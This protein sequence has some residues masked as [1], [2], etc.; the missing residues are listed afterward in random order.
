MSTRHSIF[1]SRPSE[2]LIEAEMTIKTAIDGWEHHHPMVDVIDKVEHGLL[3]RHRW[4]V[5]IGAILIQMSLGAIYAWGVFTGELTD[6]SGNFGFTTT[7]TQ[8]VFSVGLASFAA[9]MLIA[10][11]LV[12]D[13]GPRP[14]AIAGGLLLAT[15]YVLAGFFGGQFWVQV[16]CI[17]VLGGSGI[18]LAYVVPIAVG[19]RWFPDKKGLMTGFAVAGFGFGALLW[20]QLAGD[21]GHLIENFGVLNTFLIYGIVFGTLV[22]LGGLLMTYPPDGWKPSG[23][24]PPEAEI[25]QEASHEFTPHSMLNRPQFYALW[26]SFAF[27]A[28]GGLM[29]IGINKLYGRDALIDSGAFTDLA[30][31]G[32]AA[33]TAYAIAFALSNGLGRIGWGF[34][35]DRIG[36]RRSM[37]IMAVTQS[38]LMIAFYYMGGSLVA[39]YVFLALTGFNFGGNFALF[40]LATANW[41]GVKNLGINY[42]LMFSAYGL[43]GI[44]GPIM[45]GMFKDAGANDGLS[46][47]LAPFL[48]AGGLCMVAA[49]LV[50]ISKEPS[51]K[52]VLEPVTA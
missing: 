12:A 10:G 32:A 13:I 45:A 11:R 16:L 19:V 2:L 5:A 49:I 52:P 28:L 31:A 40:P 21:W 24:I 44:A 46:V 27:L 34:I 25:Q 47:W 50:K 29:L 35:A 43:G 22:H 30:A 33:S 17:G 8:W 36:W 20:V 37:M 1:H 23:W 18:G 42:G 3:M 48:I 38:F 4:L 26:L 39:L 7:Q 15:G 51:L 6:K 41:F 9:M 14:V